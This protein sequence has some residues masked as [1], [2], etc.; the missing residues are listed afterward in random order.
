[1]YKRQTINSKGSATYNNAV[2]AAEEFYSAH[3]EA[4]GKWRKGP[5]M[6]LFKEVRKQLGDVKII[7]EDLGFLTKHVVKM[8]KMCIRDRDTLFRS[9]A[10]SC[11]ERKR[12][13][14][15]KCAWA[16]YYKEQ[17]SSIEPF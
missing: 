15:N 5:D 13:R 17:K 3:P 2:M 11:E 12:H 6:R 9:S 1:M 10:Y 14:D 8:L 7:A 16:G 4:K